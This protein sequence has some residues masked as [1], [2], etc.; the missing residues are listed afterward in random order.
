[1]VKAYTKSDC[2]ESDKGYFVSAELYFKNA[3]EYQM[4]YF[5]DEAGLAIAY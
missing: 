3:L 4:K 2:A 5:E 1:M